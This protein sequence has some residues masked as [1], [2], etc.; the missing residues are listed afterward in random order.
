MFK[1]IIIAFD[2]IIFVFNCIHKKRKRIISLYE[3]SYHSIK[4]IEIFDKI[5]RVPSF[6]GG[7]N[8]HQRARPF[9]RII[10]IATI[11]ARR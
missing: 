6:R 5:N 11:C 3:G 2:P 8:H 4:L 7:M 10:T 9:F 1:L